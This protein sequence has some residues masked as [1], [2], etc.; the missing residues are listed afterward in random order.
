MDKI[1]FHVCMVVVDMEAAQ[2]ELTEALGVTW[3]P[4]HHSQYGEWEISVCYSHQGPPYLELVQGGEGG[5]WDT[6]QGSRIDHIG[7]FSE[8]VVKES[9]RWQAAGIPIDFDPAPYGREGVFCYHKALAAGVR[10][11]LVNEANRAVLCPPM[12]A[13]PAA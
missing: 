6:S 4:P 5:P 8:E 1:P 11:E 13:D 7:Y 2:K 10:L 12:P 3:R 9:E